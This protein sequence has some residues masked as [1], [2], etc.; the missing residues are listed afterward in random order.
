LH[1]N[2]YLRSCREEFNLTQEELVSQLYSHDI[3]LFGGLDT[4]TLS[5]WER[6]IVQPKIAKQVSLIKYFQ[7]LSGIAL[8]CWSHLTISEAEESICQAGMKN[9]IGKNKVYICNF[10]SNI[11]QMDELKIFNLRHSKQI[12]TLLELNM[13]IHK[14]FNH[15]STRISIE[16]FKTWALHP[17]NSF[18]V[19]EYKGTSLGYF[20]SLRLKPEVFDKLLNF[21]MRKDEITT[22]DFASYDEM[23]TS[24]MLSFFSIS[25][26]SAVA[27]FIRY[28]A[29]LI[30]NQSNIQE[31][32]GITKMDE[33]KK[34]GNRMNLILHKSMT[35][36]DGTVI[37]SYRQ[38][39]YNV[40]ASENVIKM[41]LTK[42][43]CPEEA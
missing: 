26:K 29:H 3:D 8:P 37:E 28:Y 35:T 1:F 23:G 19:C 15:P 43:E 10:P 4:G 18:Y 14:E 7:K 33:A 34:F 20:F 9:L 27:L 30:A 21:E 24:F 12:D 42:Q 16:Q 2:E 39:I 41:L 36:E 32:G 11:I 25:N 22:D 6:S 5:K 40:L 17:S 13:N 38:D 31:I